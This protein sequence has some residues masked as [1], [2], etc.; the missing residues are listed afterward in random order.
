MESRGFQPFCQ[1]STGKKETGFRLSRMVR[2]GGVEGIESTLK[3]RGL[4]WSFGFGDRCSPSLRCPWLRNPVPG[5][6]V[7]SVEEGHDLGTVTNAVYI[8]GSSIDAIGDSI[9]HSP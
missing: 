5:L 6:V 2:E 3:L 1:G 7:S 4:P 8:E 9:L